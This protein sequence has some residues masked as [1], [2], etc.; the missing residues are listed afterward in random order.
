MSIPDLKT[1]EAKYQFEGLIFDL[2]GTLVDS[3]EQHFQAWRIALDQYGAGGIFPEDVF[4][5]MGGRPTT[6][7]VVELNGDHGLQLDPDV[8][9]FEKR[10]AFTSL[11]PEISL[12][13]STCD[14]VKHYRGKIPM[15]VA[16]G[17]T[18]KVVE[19]TLAAAGISELFDEVVTADDV[20]AGKPAP[21]C[22][23]KAAE[24]LE[25]DPAKCLVFEDA[26]SGVMGAQQAGMQV[27]VV[28]APVRVHK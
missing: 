25:V 27:I 15:A 26:P 20:A 5:A 13:Q 14:I 12:I 9:A 10:K 2:D 22:F 24:L 6:D 7:I 11:L 28:P 21:D 3:M 19:S 23:L 8:I 18:R 17:G 1:L 16:S 4:Y